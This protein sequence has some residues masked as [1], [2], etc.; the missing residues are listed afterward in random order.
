VEE[1]MKTR[2][3]RLSYFRYTHYLLI[4]RIQNEG[5]FEISKRSHIK[6]DETNPVMDLSLDEV[7][8]IKIGDRVGIHSSLESPWE[9][10]DEKDHF[11]AGLQIVAF[12]RLKAKIRRVQMFG[13]FCVLRKEMDGSGSNSSP[14]VMTGEKMD[15]IAL[16]CIN[17]LEC[18][19]K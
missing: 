6:F 18:I 8:G 4:R 19:D 16:F 13:T 11:S 17:A 15:K 12:V 2:F 3:E 7:D 9:P 1:K 5:K 10:A 14:F